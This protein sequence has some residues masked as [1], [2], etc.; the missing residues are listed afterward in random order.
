MNKTGT[1]GSGSRPLIVNADDYAMDD[2]VDAAILRLAELGAVTATSA[3]VLSPTWPEAARKLRDAPLSRGLHLDFTSPFVSVNASL[4]ALMW[5][6]FA[7]QLDAGGVR[8]AIE[9][10]L[11]LYETAMGAMPE[12]VDGHQHVHQ[13]PIIREALLQG[14]QARYGEQVRAIAIRDC[15]PKRWRGLKAAIVGA[16]GAN[17]FAKRARAH[18]HAMNSDFAGVYDFAVRANLPALWRGWLADLHGT[19]PLIMCHVSQAPEREVVDDPIRAARINEYGWLQSAAY[20]EC[21]SIH[22]LVPAM[23]QR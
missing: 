19:E 12:F 21:L 15:A 14:L 11:T 6:A 1:A 18:G 9:R 2:A 16:T 13:F 3:M 5:R 20:R 4:G 10:Q 7:R 17:E 23:W 8:A 22:N